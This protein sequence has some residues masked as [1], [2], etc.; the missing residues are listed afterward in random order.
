MLTIITE[1]RQAVE[2]AGG[3]PVWLEDPENHCA[4]VLLE[5]EA[6]SRLQPPCQERRASAYFDIPEGSAVP[7]PRSYAISPSCSKTRRCE[8]NGSCITVTNGSELH[9]A[10]NP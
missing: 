7:M 1:Q 5:E 8:A 9:P 10:R 2:Q 4:Y 3:Q 6:Y